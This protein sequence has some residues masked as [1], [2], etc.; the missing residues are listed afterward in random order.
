MKSVKNDLSFYKTVTFVLR[1]SFKTLKRLFPSY[2]AHK[3]T[4]A[5]VLHWQNLWNGTICLF[6]NAMTALGILDLCERNTS[7]TFLDPVWQ[8]N[9]L[10]KINL[11]SL[12]NFNFSSILWKQCCQ[13]PRCRSSW[14]YVKVPK[15]WPAV[16]KKRFF[17]S[18]AK[19]SASFSLYI[20]K[21]KRCIRL[22]AYPF[23]F[24]RW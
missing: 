18:V 9:C 19:C 21:R 8:N 13:H 16:K 11:R 24:Q 12:G 17:S 4:G 1:N 2:S 14:C 10:K 23:F 22:A 7:Y 5:V 15:Q 3:Q 6:D 20:C